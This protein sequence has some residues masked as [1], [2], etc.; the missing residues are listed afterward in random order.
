MLQPLG[1]ADAESDRPR[2]V[3][4]PN[5]QKALRRLVQRLRHG[6]ALPLPLAPLSDAFQRMLKAVRVREALRGHPAFVAGVAPVQVPFRVSLDLD[7]PVVL[8]AH[9]QAAAAVIHPCTVRLY[10]AKLTIHEKFS[11]SVRVWV[12]RLDFQAVY[13]SF[14]SSWISLSSDGRS[15]MSWTSM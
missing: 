10:P 13:L 5:A 11:C 12:C 3:L 4:F 15:L 7:N 14:S 9:Q 6:D 8:Y 1:H 2:A